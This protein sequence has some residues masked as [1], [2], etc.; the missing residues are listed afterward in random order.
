MRNN[1]LYG[2]FLLAIVSC[3][4]FALS[5]QKAQLV[6]EWS[7]DINEPNGRNDTTEP[8]DSATITPD[9]DI[10][11]WEGAIDAEFVIGTL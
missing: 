6:E 10:T 5:C 2:Q 8:K 3:M 1:F 4:F 11:E 7:D 9:F